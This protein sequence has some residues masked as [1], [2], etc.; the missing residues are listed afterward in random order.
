M[1][2]WYL[3]HPHLFG[4]LCYSIYPWKALSYKL[5]YEKKFAICFALSILLPKSFVPISPKRMIHLRTRWSGV[6]KRQKNNEQ[7]R[8]IQCYLMTYG[9]QI[10]RVSPVFAVFSI[11]KGISRPRTHEIIF[12]G[13]SCFPACV[14]ILCI[15]LDQNACLL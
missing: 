13:F 5:A 1:T 6:V 14:G 10:S 11:F 7:R 12:Q 9:S 15:V 4:D 8:V 3:L 2:S